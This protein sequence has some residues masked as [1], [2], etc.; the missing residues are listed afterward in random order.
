MPIELHCPACGKTI[1]A[2]DDAG[3]KRGK[4]PYCAASV[5]I[6]MPHAANEGD[7]KIAPVDEAAERRREKLLKESITIA[8]AVAHEVGGVPDVRGGN[9]ARPAIP[10]ETGSPN[11]AVSDL[12]K[13]YLLAMK[14]SQLESCE[15]ILRQLRR[16]KEAATEHVQG[17]L[18]DQVGARVPGIPDK[19]VHAF[20]KNLG[21]RLEE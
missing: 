19:L 2:P 3:G 18:L 13:D 10:R 17:L 9:A 15:S 12:V 5:Y 21:E 11:A 20:L 1:K 7:I 14:E 6:P 4:C 8:A 16:Q